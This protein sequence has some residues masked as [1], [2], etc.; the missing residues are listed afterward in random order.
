VVA[1]L[2]GVARIQ[3]GEEVT[4][5]SFTFSFFLHFSISSSLLAA[6]KGEIRCDR[7][8]CSTPRLR[9]SGWLSSTMANDGLSICCSPPPRKTVTSL[10]VSFLSSAKGEISPD[11]WFCWMI[12]RR[13]RRWLSSRKGHGDLPICLFPLLGGIVTSSISG[14]SKF[15]NFNMRNMINLELI[16]L[17]SEDQG[18]HV[19]G[20]TFCIW[21]GKLDE[22]LCNGKVRET[23]VL[24]LLIE[25]SITGVATWTR[26]GESGKAD[27]TTRVLYHGTCTLALF[28]S[29]ELYS[30]S[31]LVT[32]L[33]NDLSRECMYFFTGLCK[34]YKM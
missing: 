4:L 34:T 12:R 16:F 26:T 8:V 30:C 32:S 1:S 13:L 25:S 22:A 20:K 24:C 2:P 11:R 6:T 3:V 23:K 7:W 17:S 18:L 15:E 28:W 19:K 21:S 5:A 29:R 9:L 14:K 27:K 31:V 10:S 33:C